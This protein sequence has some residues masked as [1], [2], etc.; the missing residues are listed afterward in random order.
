MHERWTDAFAATLRRGAPGA[1]VN[2]LGDEG[3]AG[4]RAAYPGSTGSRLAAIKG[5]YDPTNLFRR[6]QNIRPPARDAAAGD[7][8]QERW[9]A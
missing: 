1:Y 8:L 4:V 3:E 6:N 2:F 7:P 9:P 5:R